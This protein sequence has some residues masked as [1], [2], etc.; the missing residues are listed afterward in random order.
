METP[1]VDSARHQKPAVHCHDEDDPTLAAVE[2]LALGVEDAPVTNEHLMCRTLRRRQIGHRAA[3]DFAG[4]L[5]L[6]GR[7]QL[8]G[9]VGRTGERKRQAR[10]PRQSGE[11]H[12]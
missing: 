10:Q 11:G 7:T 4:L 1:G 6:V 8:C 5:I 2:R 9:L 12:R 3:P